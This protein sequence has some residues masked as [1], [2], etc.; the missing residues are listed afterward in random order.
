M[1]RKGK[2]HER[3]ILAGYFISMPAMISY[4]AW[5]Y[6][7]AYE[8]INVL[9]FLLLFVR[10]GGRYLPMWVVRLSK[11]IFHVESVTMGKIIK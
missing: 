4:I 8:W 5:K 10:E 7:P 11:N 9:V 3:K 1:N 2:K 6:E